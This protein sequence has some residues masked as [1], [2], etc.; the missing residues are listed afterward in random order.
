MNIRNAALAIVVATGMVGCSFKGAGVPNAPIPF[1][2][3]DYQVMGKTTADACGGYVFG[4]DWVHLFG[5]ERASVK[6]SS[7]VLPISLPLPYGT[8]PEE[9]RALYLAL[10]LMPDATHLLEPRVETSFKGLGWDFL[11]LFGKRCATVHARGVK[12]GEKA[13]SRLND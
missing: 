2:E 4:I 3:A 13:F 1:A 7:S 5:D 6:A 10:E 12:I 9:A 11:P 8:T